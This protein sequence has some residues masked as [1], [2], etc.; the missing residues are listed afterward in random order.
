M[1]VQD[2]KHKSICNIFIFKRIQRNV[3]SHINNNNNIK[4]CL[5]ASAD[6]SIFKFHFSYIYFDNKN[7]NTHAKLF[8]TFIKPKK[9][10][11]QTHSI[12]F[13]KK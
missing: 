9:K 3:S 11:Y 13:T 5:R 2:I 4:F 8:T 10:S 12:T 1:R 7:L 6:T